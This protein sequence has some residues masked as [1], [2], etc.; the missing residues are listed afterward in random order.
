MSIKPLY[1]EVIFLPLPLSTQLV[2]SFNEKLFG[3]LVKDIEAMDPSILK[4]EPA[5][6]K[7]QRRE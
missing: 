1:H 3:L 5:S 2:F 7:R 6:G 4:G